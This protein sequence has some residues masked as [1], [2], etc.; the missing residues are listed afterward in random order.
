MDICGT[1]T[2]L[3]DIRSV[4]EKRRKRYEMLEMWI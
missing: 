2:V 1:E 4:N 3:F